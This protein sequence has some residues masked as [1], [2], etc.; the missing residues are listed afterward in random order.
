MYCVTMAISYTITTYLLQ[1]VFY[2]MLFNDVKI[3][4]KTLVHM[5]TML[6]TKKR[7]TTMQKTVSGY[8]TRSKQHSLLEPPLVRDAIFLSHARPV[9]RSVD[10]KRA[11]I[12]QDSRTSHIWTKRKKWLIFQGSFHTILREQIKNFVRICGTIDELLEESHET[13]KTLTQNRYFRCVGKTR[14]QWAF[15]Q[16]ISGPRPDRCLLYTSDAADD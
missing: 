15:G 11:R 8:D 12:A 16:T 13:S 7:H 6:S 14:P 9:R 10:F 4:Q 3:C 5:T 1:R 2:C